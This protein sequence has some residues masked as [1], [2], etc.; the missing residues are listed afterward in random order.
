M[1][2]T[3]ERTQCERDRLWMQRAIALAWRAAG[4]VAPNP[5]VGAVVVRDGT[6]VGEGCT[7]PPGG[8]HAEVV[9]LEEAGERAR[10]ATL[11]VTLEPCAHYGRTPPCVHA[12]LRTGIRRVVIAIRDPYPEVDGR[13][14]AALRAAGLEVEVGLEAEAAAEAVAGYLKR[15]RTGFPEVTLKYAMTLDGRLATRTGHSRWITGPEA[16]RYAHRLRDRHDAIL[17][18]VG[19][20]LQDDP[21]LTTRLDP[22]EC[23]D[24][25]PHHPLRVILD[26]QART[27]PTARMLSPAVPGQTLIVTTDAAPPDRVAALREAGAEIVTVPARCGKVDIRSALFALGARGINGV[28]VEGGGRVLGSLFDAGLVDRIVAFVAP[29]LVGGSEAPVPF[30]GRGV[31]TMDQAVRLRDV[32]VRELGT[33]VV[34]EGRVRP[35]EI[36]E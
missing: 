15:L 30:A 28:L 29:V 34:I 35:V 36:P 25:G 33:D 26:S 11:Y 9:A 2:A 24:G 19:T 12:I 7:K 27:P 3:R 17:V 14:I 20:V 5:A 22:S 32:R 31:E 23:G 1:E 6:V 21:E 8:P 16:R 13:G 18:G 10:G 4:R